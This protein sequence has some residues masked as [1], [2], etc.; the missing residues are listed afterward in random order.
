MSFRT[1][2]AL[3][4]SGGHTF[5]GRREREMCVCVTLLLAEQIV[6][7][8]MRRAA[9]Q[10]KSDVAAADTDDT[11]LLLFQLQINII[12]TL[13]VFL[14]HNSIMLVSF[15]FKIAKSAN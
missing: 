3:T 10:I 12:T 2:L 8:T 11:N 14:V 6:A 9:V 1:K 7:D 13:N 5:C 15:E 4:V